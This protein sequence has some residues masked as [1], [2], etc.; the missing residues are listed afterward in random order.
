[1]IRSAP[2]PA[3]VILLIAATAWVAGTVLLAV[4][5]PMVFSFAPPK[6][7]LLSREA[8]GTVFGALLMTWSQIIDV[9][10]WPLCLGALA[11]LAYALRG[12]RLAL[13]VCM[14]ALAACTTAHA[15]ARHSTVS[16][17]AMAAQLRVGQGDEVAF[18]KAHA[19]N[20]TLVTL[21]ALI[22][23]GLV[24]GAGMALARRPFAAPEPA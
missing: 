18:A 16:T 1:M 8:A 10:L 22:A 9:S 19:R 11:T 14:M 5:A 4:A 12:Q 6:G 21:E 2:R 15:L 13:I 7:E 24:V 20:R 3:L 17:V 23:L